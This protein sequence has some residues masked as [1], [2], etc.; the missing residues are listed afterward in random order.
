MRRPCGWVRCLSTQSRIGNYGCALIARIVRGQLLN[1]QSLCHPW[2]ELTWS[3]HHGFDRVTPT[4]T[5]L[6]IEDRVSDRDL[7]NLRLT[8]GLKRDGPYEVIA[9]SGKLVKLVG[10]SERQHDHSENGTRDQFVGG[11]R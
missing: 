7:A 2:L 10:P 5:L 8:R 4:P 11:G 3:C 9:L 1:R 6:A